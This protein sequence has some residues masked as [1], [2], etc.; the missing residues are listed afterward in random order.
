MYLDDE[1]GLRTQEVNFS[2]AIPVHNI[3]K[4]FWVVDGRVEIQRVTFGSSGSSKE[5]AQFWSEPHRFFVPAYRASLDELLATSIELL[6]KNPPLQQGAPA[7]FKP[8][9]L[10]IQDIQSAVEFIVV[11]VEAN[12]SDKLKEIHFDLHLSQPALWILP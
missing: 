12:R 7:K 3:G 9:T 8:V 5:S 11:A 4:P 6:R 1:H 10:Y 2:A